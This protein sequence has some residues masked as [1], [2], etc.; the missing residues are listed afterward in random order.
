MSRKS[1]VNTCEDVRLESCRRPARSGEGCELFE[2]VGYATIESHVVRDSQDGA[3][4]ERYGIVVVMN[5]MHR[6]ITRSRRLRFDLVSMRA[7][8]RSPRLK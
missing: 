1:G 5:F 2:P 3:I 6:T 8:H 4:D 7:T